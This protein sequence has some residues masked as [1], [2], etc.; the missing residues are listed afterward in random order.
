[1]AGAGEGGESFSVARVFSRSFGILGRSFI[2]Y[3]ALAL[4]IYSIPAALSDYFIVSYGGDRSD[5]RFGVVRWVLLSG[6]QIPVLAGAGA[7]L[8][9]AVT[10]ATVERLASRPAMFADALGAALRH[11]PPVLAIVLIQCL[12]MLMAGAFMLLPIFGLASI[13]TPMALG[14]AGS[15][16]GI[17]AIV[18][19]ALPGVLLY[20]LWIAAIPAYVTERTGISAAFGRSR[21]LTRG[22]RFRIFL[23][24]LPVI[25]GIYGL[26]FAVSHIVWELV[27][28]AEL[29]YLLIL[30]AFAAL[31][32]AILAVVIA[33]IYVE[34]RD[35]KEGV[36]PGELVAIFN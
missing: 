36:D 33:C 20:T 22:A 2:P 34:L 7:V 4:L 28:Y 35:A 23:I 10:R 9:A 26:E 6:L 3:L 17:T 31:T 25:A 12:A 8:Q 14:V 24:L 29:P 5:L 32:S 13:M 16:I 30:S 27:S 15:L 21:E 19:V 1:M 18:L 11:A